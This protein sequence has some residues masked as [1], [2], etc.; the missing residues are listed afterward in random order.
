MLLRKNHLI[1][2]APS[3]DLVIDGARVSLQHACIRW[4]A[5]GW[6]LKDLGSLNGTQ[7]NGSG[8]ELRALE[9]GD[10]ISFGHGDELWELVDATGPELMVVSQSG[11]ITLTADDAIVAIP[12]AE[13][14]KASV[15][16]NSKGTWV[17]ER[18]DDLVELTDQQAFDVDGERWIFHSPEAVQQTSSVADLVPQR[19]ETVVLHFEVSSDEE[20]VGLRAESGGHLVDLG[21]RAHNY[22]LLTLARKKLSDVA[23]NV[24][25]TGCGWVYQDDLLRDLKVTP[26]QLNLDIFRIRKQFGALDV[27]D[28]A[29]IVQRRPLTKQIRI[30]TGHILETRA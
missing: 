7:V 18:T 23:E 20:F 26:G 1:G 24:R 14:P 9:R 16:R 4:T 3:S 8:V 25:A 29:S 2:R 15:Y 30:G 28:S 11:R 27:V 6:E 21:S 10:R 19:I 5:N 17:L 22:L 13:E 12:R